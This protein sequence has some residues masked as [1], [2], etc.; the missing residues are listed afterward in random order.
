MLN[1]KEQEDLLIAIIEKANGSPEFKRSLIENSNQAIQTEFGQTLNVKDGYSINFKESSLSNT[2]E[3]LFEEFE[4]ELV[5]YIPDPVE[6]KNE[7]LYEE[8]L[9]MLVGGGIQVMLDKAFKGIPREYQKVRQ[10]I[11]AW[12]NS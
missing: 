10:V 7:E 6:N 9:D 11:K 1:K 3:K 8:E 12:W 2:T 5:I 4:R